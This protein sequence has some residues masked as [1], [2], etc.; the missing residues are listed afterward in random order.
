MIDSFFTFFDD[1][2]LDNYTDFSL[3]N[4][5][6]KADHDLHL[7]ES[8]S[9]RL[10]LKDVEGRECSFLSIEDINIHPDYR[11]KQLLTRLLDIL[12][13]KN[14]PLFMDDIINHRLF[15]YLHGRGYKN[16]K[17]NSGYGWKRSMYKLSV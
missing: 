3:F 13:S 10:T 17:H 15:K 7:F 16:L 11:S 6:I 9:I 4:S 12:E 8:L 1:L 14:I 2:S 5:D